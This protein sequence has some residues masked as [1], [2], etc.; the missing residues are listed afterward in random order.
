MKCP[1][2]KNNIAHDAL[3]CPYCKTR[4]GILCT[5]C[6]HVNP[7]GQLKCTQCGQELL[8]ICKKCNGVNFPT[9]L[10]CRKCGADFGESGNKKNKPPQKDN[11]LIFTPKF[12]SFKDGLEILTNALSNKNIKI[13]SIT[14]EKGGGKTSVLYSAIKKIEDKNI[15]LGKCTPLT[16]L[17]P[18]G[19]IQDM[20]LN[21]FSLPN[22]GID[23]PELKKNAN[24]FFSKE[25]KFLQPPEISDLMNFIYSFNDGNYEDIIINKKRTY[26]ILS[27]I[28]EAFISSGRFIFI[29]DNF[30]F[31]DGFSAEFITNLI[32]KEKNWNNLKFILLYNNP[33]P[34]CGLFGLDNKN[35]SSFAD[36]N[37]KPVTE[38][39]F[40][41]E[42]QL[43]INQ[44]IEISERERELILEKSAGNF[45]FIQQAIS[46]AFDCKI[47]DKAF[48][49]PEDFSQLVKDRLDILKKSNK[50]AYK[51]LCTS[52]ILGD[53]ININLV[54]EILAFNESEFNDVINYLE[55]S[56][57]IRKF[58][59]I[60]YEFNNLLLWETIL[61]N[62]TRDSEFD[63]IN[64]KIGKAISVFNLNTNATMAMIAHNLHQ[65][66]M[67]FDI[68]TK[69]TRLA[70][71]IGD[72]NLYVIAQKQCLALLNEFNEAE[73]I[74]IRYNISEKLGKLLSEYDPDEALEFL[75]D[76][77]SNARA[78]ND[79]VKE[80][81]LLGYL[82]LC[83]SKIGNYFGNVECVDNV[84]KKLKEGQELEKAMIISAKLQALLD[85][86]NCGEVISLADNDVL[87]VLNQYLSKP[88]L[89][90]LFP[91]GLLFDTWLKVYLVLATA[92]AL[93]GN[94]RA[95]EV[96]KNLFAIIDKHKINDK[97]LIAKAKIV[98]AYAYTMRGNIPTSMKLLQDIDSHYRD[99]FMDEVSVSRLNLVYII[100]KFLTNDKTDLKEDLFEAV[101]FANNAGD[102]FTKNILK[103]LLGKVFKDDNKAQHALEIYNEQVTY[104]AK[105]KM[106]LGALLGWYLIADATIV[107]ENSKSAIDIASQALEIT[108]NPSIENYFF[109][110][111]LRL[112]LAKAYMNIADFTT[113]KINIEEGLK[114][115]KKCKMHDILSRLYLLYGKY[116]LDIGKVAA[117]NQIEYLRGAAVMFEKSMELIVK[118]T[119]NQYIK[120]LL[121]FEKE[122]LNDFCTQNSIK[123]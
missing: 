111:N 7:V 15:C 44:D 6:K 58:D 16:Q 118:E 46:Y 43:N 32:R 95:F 20:L 71:Y 11:S 2:C 34:V 83:C 36:I 13:V 75:P 68:W 109:A 81:E 67:S 60:Y 77:I 99:S 94:E 76:A 97:Q 9:A 78:N 106:A 113:A 112:V 73:T 21:L 42:I 91:L 28:F 114:L 18:G 101:T 37:L 10:K 63:D 88:R 55:I 120:D 12:Y 70:A 53:K 30:D 115:A 35:L 117:Q 59:E 56:K 74:K 25:F 62:I 24:E 38:S 79:E 50:T 116:Y 92:L 5:S 29:V 93:Q 123:L 80:I 89:N 69:T 65:T 82:A 105:E 85:I 45:A 31:I 52:A 61:K 33:K 40:D 104:F 27:K 48:V 23:N 100:N 107:T 122:K 96:L 57:F 86:G 4:T 39:E 14:G 22:F 26:S 19:V 84:L 54:R 49:L 1:V 64:V 119:Q 8:K 108:L 90:K 72:I 102:N 66:R 121:N 98:Q 41:T 3:K 103:T 51:V 17:T 110:V 47:T 87:P